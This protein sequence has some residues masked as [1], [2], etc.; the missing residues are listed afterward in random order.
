MGRRRECDQALEV[1]V[2]AVLREH[3]ETKPKNGSA[4]QRH[5]RERSCVLQKHEPVIAHDSADIARQLAQELMG[6][7]PNANT[8]SKSP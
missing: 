4:W 6:K 5:A 7:A 1:R 2:I 8:H 3:I